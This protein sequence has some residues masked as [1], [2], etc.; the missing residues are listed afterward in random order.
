[1]SK[2]MTEENKKQRQKV[3]Y[4]KWYKK[5]KGKL[6]KERKRKYRTDGEYYKKR[7]VETKEYRVKKQKL[8]KTEGKKSL[9]RTYKGKVYVVH[10]IGQAAKALGVETTVIR[11]WET[12]GH[13]PAS[14]FGGTHRVYTENQ[15]DLMRM[16]LSYAEGWEPDGGL[17]LVVSTILS[18][19]RQ[20]I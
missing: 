2:S 11:K 18:S 10:T 12:A 9:T 7:M 13:I 17:D 20:E 15:I 19:W 4:N 16:L 14:M 1:M 3:A 8:P 5:N 6:S